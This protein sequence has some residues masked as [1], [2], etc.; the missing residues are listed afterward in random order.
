MSINPRQLNRF[1]GAIIEK[2]DSTNVLFHNHI[3][4]GFLRKY[5]LIQYK[6]LNG[7]A[8]ILAINEGATAL[9]DLLNNY[10]Y[11]LN[12]D[13]ER[14][15]D[16][17]FTDTTVP[18]KFGIDDTLHNYYT[19]NWAP[20]NTEA[21]ADF[22]NL[23]STDEKAAKLQ[24]LLVKNLIN[25]CNRL[26]VNTRRPG[27]LIQVDLQSVKSA[28]TLSMHGTPL[29]KFSVRFKTNVLLPAD[30]GLGRATAFGAG[31]IKLGW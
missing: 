13:N 17:L 28:G 12:F 8:G 26:G 6:I 27:N 29:Q 22:D 1:R 23:S 20:F 5:P 30:I 31:C 19:S 2:A 16:L 25:L 15:T 14:H 24:S 3:G 4:D 9:S 11:Q 7:K 10:D 18:F 21:L